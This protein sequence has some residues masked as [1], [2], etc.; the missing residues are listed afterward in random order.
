MF[1]SSIVNAIDADMPDPTEAERRGQGFIRAL[2]DLVR[3]RGHAVERAAGVHRFVLNGT[4]VEWLVYER[5]VQRKV[6]LTKKEA[7][8]GLFTERA[9]REG[10]IEFWPS[11]WLVLMVKTDGR[12]ESRI[13]ERPRH[14][15]EASEILDRFES[16]AAKAGAERRA[17]E[18]EEQ[19]SRRRAAE[20]AR[21]RRVETYRWNTMQEMMTAAE[22]AARLRRFIAFIASH[23][24]MRPDQECRVRKWV[25]WARAHADAIDPAIRE[26]DDVLAQLGVPKR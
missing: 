20:R 15:F 9:K 22:D 12:G 17:W 6:P 2:L 25:R 19:R 11:G 3:Q 10:K 24:P 21:S 7:K 23:S 14:R 5:S 18:E 1:G 16:M 26:F 4:A 13:V 8:S